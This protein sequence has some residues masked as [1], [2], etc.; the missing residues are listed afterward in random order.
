MDVIL[1]TAQ[2]GWMPIEIKLG[3]AAN[4]DQA[5]RNL[6]RLRK[7]TDTA[8]VGDRP[9]LVVVTGT[10]YGYE[11]PDRVTVVPLTSLRAGSASPRS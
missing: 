5:A 2:G 9:K 1:E 4:I 7:R 11:R 10:G 8:H 6:P 3:G